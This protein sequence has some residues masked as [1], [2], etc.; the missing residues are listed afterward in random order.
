MNYFHHSFQSPLGNLL[1]VASEQELLALFFADTITLS[2]IFKKITKDSQPTKIIDATNSIIELTKKELKLYFDKKLTKF[3]VPIKFIGTEFQTAVWHELITIPYSET[4]SYAAIAKGIHKSKAIRATGSA[5][6]ANNINI[7]VPCH[8]IIHSNG[9]T[10]NYY[11]NT[12][13]INRKVLLL[14]L[15]ENK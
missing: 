13:N 9:A 14:Q 15:E 3:S 7:I 1:S 10:G 6:G 4:R 12:E 2:D 11:G 5:I 8:R